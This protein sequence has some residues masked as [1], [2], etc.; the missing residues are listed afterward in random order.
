MP[1]TLLIDDTRKLL[2]LVYAGVVDIAERL[3]AIQESDRTLDETG[4]HRVLVDWRGA[5]RRDEPLD[6][7]NSFAT[8]IAASALQRQSRI[9]FLGNRGSFDNLL[10]SN[11]ARARHVSLEDF[12]ERDAAIAWLLEWP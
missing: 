9:A 10:V 3:Q 8:R 11:L 7:S 5:T 6:M 2:E 12:T 4:Y 1:H